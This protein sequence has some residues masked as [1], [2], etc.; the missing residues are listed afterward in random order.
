MMWGY[1]G[2]RGQNLSVLWNHHPFPLPK[3]HLGLGAFLPPFPEG[4]IVILMMGVGFVFLS[5]H[6]PVVLISMVFLILLLYVNSIR[7]LY[8]SLKSP[9]FSFYNAQ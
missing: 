2:I 1:M 7:S 5:I 6:I 9:Y 3:R 4:S 8:V